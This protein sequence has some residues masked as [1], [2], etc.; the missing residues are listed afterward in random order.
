MLNCSD[1]F[2]H[3]ISPANIYLFKVSIE[4]R[5]EICSKL[6]SFSSV[7]I[8]DFEQ[9]NTSLESTFRSPP[10]IKNDTTESAE[11]TPESNKIFRS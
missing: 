5:F 1:F 6:T 4:K 9:V 8:I 3:R 2:I 7:S 11:L 10:D